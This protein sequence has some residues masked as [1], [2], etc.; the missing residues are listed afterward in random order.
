MVSWPSVQC[1][2]PLIEFTM[3]FSLCASRRPFKLAGLVFTTLLFLFQPFVTVS[4]LP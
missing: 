4:V 3:T 1:G 2:L